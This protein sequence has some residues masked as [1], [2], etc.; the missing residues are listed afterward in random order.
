MIGFGSRTT[1]PGPGVLGLA[2][3]PDGK[4]LATSGADPR[5]AWEVKVWDPVTGQERA[6]L[7]GK[8]PATGSINPV[9]PRWPH[10]P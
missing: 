5:R 3:S 6:T 9:F 10:S 1:H 4:T 2:F 8:A 7:T